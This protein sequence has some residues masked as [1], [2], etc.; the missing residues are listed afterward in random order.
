MRIGGEVPWEAWRDS[1]VMTRAEA[2]WTFEDEGDS[3]LLRVLVNS[4]GLPSRDLMSALL[5]FATTACS[6]CRVADELV[7]ES[8]P[9]DNP[10]IP[11]RDIRRP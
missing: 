2:R 10:T 4:P 7:T 9:H 6:R 1:G 3:K 11:G 8:D 5:N